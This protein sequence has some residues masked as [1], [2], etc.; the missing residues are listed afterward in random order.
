M[1]TLG[2]FKKILK[3]EGPAGFVTGLGARALYW[4]AATHPAA[5]RPPTLHAD[6]NKGRAAAQHLR[7][8]GFGSECESGE[9][10]WACSKRF[11]KR[12]TP[13]ASS[14]GWAP[15]RC[16]GELQPAEEGQY[17]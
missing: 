7:I 14:R 5:P 10:L 16:T 6:R 11:L 12:K 4:Y 15:E 17:A 1:G 13:W 2:M 8:L 3:E 9:V